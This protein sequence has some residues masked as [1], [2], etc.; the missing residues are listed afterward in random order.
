VVFDKRKNKQTNNNKKTFSPELAQI[1]LF[2]ARG[3]MNVPAINQT[4][5]K[6]S[7]VETP[8]N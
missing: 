8:V 1:R 2:S 3:Q 7:G 5:L 6:V 4:Q